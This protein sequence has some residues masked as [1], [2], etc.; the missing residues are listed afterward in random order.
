MLFSNQ[1]LFQA[2]LMTLFHR[3]FIGSPFTIARFQ[4]S[5]CSWRC[6]AR[7]FRAERSAGWGRFSA[8]GTVRRAAVERCDWRRRR[9]GSWRRSW[10]APASASA[11]VGLLLKKLRR[12]SAV[13]WFGL[14]YIPSL[15]PSRVAIEHHSFFNYLNCS[16]T[17]N[18]YLNKVIYTAFASILHQQFSLLFLDLPQQAIHAVNLVKYN[19]EN[20]G[21]VTARE[22]WWSVVSNTL[23]FPWSL[24]TF[25]MNHPSRK[26]KVQ[27]RGT[28]PLDASIIVP[29]SSQNRRCADIT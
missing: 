17:A 15:E 10:P 1:L 20:I 14:W 13:G 3:T 21:E 25:W 4:A 19:V 6:G 7:R 28:G 22:T 27:N 18:G 29:I 16:L 26:T 8:R 12:S 23:K 2:R 11:R 5:S 9:R 24:R